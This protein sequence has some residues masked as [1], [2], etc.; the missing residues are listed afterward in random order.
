MMIQHARP[1]QDHPYY[2]EITQGQRLKVPS[3]FVSW[4]QGMVAQTGGEYDMSVFFPAQETASNERPDWLTLGGL[5]APV[6]RRR[7]TSAT[8]TSVPGRSTL[9]E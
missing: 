4:Q 8:R 1:D 9:R 6:R 2:L 5:R 7:R 3:V